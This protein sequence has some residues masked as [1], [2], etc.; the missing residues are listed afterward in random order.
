MKKEEEVNIGPEDFWN[1]FL[2]NGAQGILD[3]YKS[4]KID[5]KYKKPEEND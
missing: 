4:P 1:A 2:K 3:L 5:D